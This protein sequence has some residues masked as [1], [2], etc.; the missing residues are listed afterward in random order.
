[1][2]HRGGSR[3]PRARTSW[4]GVAHWYDGWVGAN[5]S[6]HHRQLAVPLALALLAPRR[7]ERIVDVGCGQGV[8]AE[9]IARGG[10]DYLGV[11]ASPRLVEYARRRH[12]RA[13]FAVGD[14]RRLALTGRGFDAAV[15]LLSLQDMDPLDAVIAATADALAPR[16]R[17]TLVLTHPCFRIPRQSGWGDDPLRRLRYRRVDRYLTPLAVPWRFAF[18]ERR[19]RTVSFHRPL[20]DYV[21]ALSSRGFAVDALEEIAGLEHEPSPRPPGNPDIPLFLGLRARRG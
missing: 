4:D 14:A 6:E 10:A 1:M 15:F 21:A 3:R 8:L 2:D 9:A 13:R 12:P 5:G 11:D 19:A 7:G 18:G 17:I 16:A 20:R